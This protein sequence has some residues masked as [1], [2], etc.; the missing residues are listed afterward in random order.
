LALRLAGMKPPRFPSLWDA[1]C[2]IV[3]FQ[4]VSLSAAV[5]T[6]NRFVMALGPR[7]EVEGVSYWGMPTPASVLSAEMATL[8]GCGL[9]ASKAQT[10][11]GLAAQALVG[12]L[13]EALLDMASDEELI[14]RLIRLPGIGPWSAQVALLRGFGRLSVFPAGDSGATRGLRELFSEEPQPDE[15]AR[16]LLQRLGAWRGYLYF[17]LL[18]RRLL[19]DGEMAEA[20]AKDL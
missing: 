17:M 6:L 19:A 14:A 4:L 12:E 20:P 15:A 13:D 9:S 3:P 7:V 16:A 1:F 11:R 8:R 18:G 10:L 2:Q 5:A